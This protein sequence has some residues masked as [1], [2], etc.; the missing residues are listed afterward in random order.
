MKYREK[1]IEIEA[2]QYEGRWLDLLRWLDQK[3]QAP[4]DARSTYGQLNNK[5]VTL[6]YAG[7]EVGVS[8]GEWV[9]LNDDLG[10]FVL[11]DDTFKLLYEA[12]GDQPGE[13][14]DDRKIKIRC[15]GCQRSGVFARFLTDPPL[16][17]GT[18]LVCSGCGGVFEVDLEEMEIMEDEGADDAEPEE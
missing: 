12:A 6:K 5:N 16:D 3:G 2:L 15:P 1:H 7:G 13:D 4:Q 14:P 9:C 17:D 8:I 18:Q 11:P 10:V